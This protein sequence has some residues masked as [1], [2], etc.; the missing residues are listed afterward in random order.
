[1]NRWMA[2]LCSIPKSW[3][4]N[5]KCFEVHTAIRMPVAVSYRVQL[6]GL[7]KGLVKLNMENVKTGM[8]RLGFSDGSFQKGKTGKS[9]LT[10]AENSTMVFCGSAVLANAFFINLC[11]G[12]TLVLGDEFSSNY[13]LTI[14]CGERIEFGSGCLLGWDTTF[15]DGDG[16]SILTMSGD[17]LNETKGIKVGNHVWIASETAFLK[18]SRVGNNNVVG[19]RST[20]LGEIDDENCVISGTPAR[21]IKRNVDWKR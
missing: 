11:S 3:Y 10:F 17:L 16:H 6:K 8:I 5:F 4:F 12:S 14:S 1:M 13:N 20:V 7:K 2:L 21:V 19:F 18:G 15:I 9:S